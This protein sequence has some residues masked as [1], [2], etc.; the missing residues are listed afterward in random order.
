MNFRAALTDRV[1]PI[2][3]LLLLSFPLSYI[4]TI[5]HEEG[6]GMLALAQ[7]G[8]F[9]GI[10]IGQ[11]GSYAL[12]SSY[13]VPIGGWMGDYVLLVIVLAL[14]WMMKPKSFLARSVVAILVLQESIGQPAYVA[15][16]QG[17]SAATL[18]ILE[19]T[20]IGYGTSVAILESVALVLFLAATYLSWRV[21][22]QYFSQSFPWIKGRRVN[23]A[24]ISFVVAG[25]VIVLVGDVSPILGTTMAL[26][27]E[28]QIAIF[29]AFLVGLSLL[30]IPAA[31]PD[32]MGRRVGGPS[33]STVVFVSLLFVEAQLVLFF[34]LPV[35]IPFP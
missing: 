21:F 27:S 8:T 34:A 35:T 31:P 11:E 13:L 4:G 24:A 25:E 28:V 2:L 17:D 12:A 15:S 18:N 22:R 32:W 1:V 29:V 5:F 30:A 33:V 7:G 10:I 14:S 19:A 20:G 3:L 9:T 23:A 6:H 16:L 26:I